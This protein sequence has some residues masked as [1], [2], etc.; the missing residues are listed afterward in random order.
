MGAGLRLKSKTWY[1]NS[2]N[3]GDV[4]FLIHKLHSPITAHQ[5]FL[6]PTQ[7]ASRWGHAVTFLHDMVM[8]ARLGFISEIF[9]KWFD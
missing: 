5:E 2:Y 4:N 6:L 8:F 1:R 3:F 7:G 9:Y